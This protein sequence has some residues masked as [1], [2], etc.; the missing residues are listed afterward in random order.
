MIRYNHYS[1]YYS[2]RRSLEPGGKKGL[3]EISQ[4]RNY[5]GVHYVV[6]TY[7]HNIL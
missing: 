5:T 6:Q 1:L 2:G 7:I 3:C 4:Q